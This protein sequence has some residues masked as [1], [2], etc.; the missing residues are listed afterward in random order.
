[1]KDIGVY[2][3][4]PFCKSK[5]YYCDFLSFTNCN[6]KIKEYV[7][8]MK[9]EIRDSEKHSIKTIYIGGGTPSY[10]DSKYIKEILDEL[11]YNDSE[12]TI[13]LNPGTVNKEKLQDYFN[14]GINRL[15]IGLQSTENSI[16][17]T[18]G[19]I[20]KYE[21]FIYTYKLAR[22]VGFKNINIDL[23]IGLPNQTLEILKNTLDKI[24]N[25][26]P[27]HISIYSLILEEETY[28]KK[29]VD[30]CNLV[31]PTEDKEREMYWYAKNRL[32]EA[33]YIHYEISNFTKK[34][35]ESKHNV[36]CWNQKEYI[37][38]GLGAHSYIDNIRY[39][40][41]DNF[42]DYMKV[43]KIIHEVQTDYSK[44]QEYVILGLRKIEGIN[45]EE[46]TNRFTRN[47][48]D[49]FKNELD[50][51]IGMQLIINENGYIKLSD[52]GIDLANIVWSEF[53]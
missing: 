31:L 9:R 19:R 1:M 50:K 51:L 53:V 3:H 26:L 43:E 4:I 11:D 2:I 42:Y 34:G 16:L 36:D 32:E 49:V 20:H 14:M 28:L 21:D 45:I 6:E 44:M 12:I 47:I 23:I 15:S 27:E 29:L 37:G 48:F 39:S 52:K 33:G 10:I 22:E 46:F 30:N 41:P 35:Y 7:E 18:I 25:L 40:N 38:F 8:N 5:C 24:I 13:E 17:N